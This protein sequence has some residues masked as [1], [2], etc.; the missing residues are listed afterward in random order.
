MKKTHII[1]PAVLGTIGAAFGVYVFK[2]SKDI[3]AEAKNEKDEID[4]MF[5][6]VQDKLD[7]ISEL[8]KEL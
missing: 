1:V 2:K 4:K 5:D 6:D 7:Q 3:D 8:A